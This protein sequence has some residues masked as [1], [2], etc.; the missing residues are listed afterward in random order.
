M[1]GKGGILVTGA[2]SGLGLETA[3]HLAERGLRVYAS[4]RDSNGEGALRAEAVRRGVRL[5]VLPLDVTDKESIQAAVRAVVAGCDGIY[6]VI[7]NAGINIRGYFEDLSEEEMQRVFDI[8]VFGT[9]AVTRAALPYMRVA[10]AGRIVIM[11]SAGGRIA[12][13]SASAYCASKFALEGFGESLAQELRPFEVYVSLV[14]PGIIRTELF[15]KNRRIAARAGD[16]RGPYHRWF[17]RSEELLDR[18][19]RAVTT[20]P[21]AVAQVVHRILVAERP[22]LRYPVGRRARLLLALRRYLP[23]RLFER[24]WARRVLQRVTGQDPSS[25]GSI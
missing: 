7:N 4:V 1:T 16:P 10:R 11:S 23:A 8:N 3:V 18:E 14:E 2:S 17:R 15:G 9:M 21:A 24:I 6:A 12:S 19:V 13:L 25:G 20:S 22:R 5:E